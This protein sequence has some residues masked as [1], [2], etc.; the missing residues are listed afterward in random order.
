MQ[1]IIYLL[2]AFLSFS[3]EQFS[4]Q[5]YSSYQQQ[6]YDIQ[7]GKNSKDFQLFIKK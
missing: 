2:I 3:H 4:S 5:D 6:L 7:N 1:E